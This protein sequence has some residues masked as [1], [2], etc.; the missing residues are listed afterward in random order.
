MLTYF[1]RQSRNAKTGP[2]PVSTSSA[3]TCPDCPLKDAGCY[4]E[5]GPLAIL[6][7]KVT[8][9]NAGLTWAEF[10]E[11]VETLPSRI[12][13]RHN[14]AGDLRGK[15][16]A[17]DRPALRQ[18]VK[19]NG[20]RR[21]FTYTHKPATRGNLAAIRAANKAGFTI[22]LS[23]NNLEHADT[24]ADTGAGPVVVVLPA[25]TLKPVKTPAG[26][27]VAICPAVISP[28]TC[29]DCGLCAMPGRKAIIGFPAHG[30]SKNKASAIA[31]EVA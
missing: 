3:E 1:T 2:I 24:L 17:I 31:R 26:R 19:S 6:W 16:N 13:W 28:L 21:G 18:L 5:G 30:A 12:L 29:F 20:K 23:A 8:A 4:A 10:L 27:T 14:Q 22:N 9:G 15:G 25:D 7:R 11:Q